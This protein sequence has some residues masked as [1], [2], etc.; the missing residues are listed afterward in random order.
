MNRATEERIRLSLSEIEALATK[1]AR[2]A[3]FEWGLAEEAG[4]ATARLAELGLAAPELLLKLLEGP[5]RGAPRPGAGGWANAGRPLCPIATG[6]A[7]ADHAGLAEGPL[8]E[9][10]ELA[11]LSCPAF[12]LPFAARA[13]A[14]RGLP[15]LV[16][17]GSAVSLVR[18]RLA[19]ALLDSASWNAGR[20]APVTLAEAAADLPGAEPTA[21]RQEISLSVWARLDRLAL[22]TTVPPSARSRAGAGA[23]GDDRD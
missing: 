22:G 4:W 9:P 3:G 14:R 8:S 10:L 20:Q 1:A 11:P 18:P 17:A 21:A 2:A 7:V 15:L 16:R 12:L 6:A 19:P 13:A 23:A 5:R